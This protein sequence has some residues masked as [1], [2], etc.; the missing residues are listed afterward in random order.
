MP[1][2]SLSSRWQGLDAR[3]SQCLTCYQDVDPLADSVPPRHA[4]ESDDEDEF[5]PLVT[6][7]QEKAPTLEVEL[8]GN[9]KSN[10]G[11]VIA[12][13]D[14]GKYWAHGAKLGE[15]TAGV[16]V[17]KTQVCIFTKV[18]CTFIQNGQIGLVFSPSWTDAT[19][20]VSEVTSRL[21]VWAMSKYAK[22][23]IDSLKPTR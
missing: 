4:L 1:Y 14:L 6:S 12:S 2:A 16:F 9:A 10:V 23:I 8:I 21:P 13:G 11:L 3:I 19:V 15:Q 20:V 18:V 22:T 7:S 17:N 5:N